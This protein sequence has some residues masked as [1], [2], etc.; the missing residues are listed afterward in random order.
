MSKLVDRLLSLARLDR[1][2]VDMEVSSV[3]LEL[4]VEGAVETFR[5]A[6]AARDLSVD[7]EL[8][9]G[10]AASTDPALLQVVINNLLENAVSYADAGSRI[11]ISAENGGA[12]VRLSI[13]NAAPIDDPENIDQIFKPFWRAD[14]LPGVAPAS[15]PGLGCRS[16]KKS[17][18]SSAARST[19][20]RLA[21]AS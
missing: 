4:L 19:P 20:R 3:P 7:C 10:V 2:E 11:R 6:A 17:S 15:T 18:R 9:D 8:P 1:S 5:E 14:N 13:A 21:G 16:V 12:H